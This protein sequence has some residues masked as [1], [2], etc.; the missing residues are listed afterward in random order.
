MSRRGR[1]TIARSRA[2]STPNWIGCGCFSASTSEPWNRQAAGDGEDAAGGVGKVAAH[3]RSHDAADVCGLTPS[4]F[5]Y[6]PVC[7]QPV[8]GVLDGGGHV[9]RDDSRTKL[10]DGNALTG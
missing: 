4:P 1:H 10:V 2:S 5:G 9:G 6:E 3:Q 8:V 7:D